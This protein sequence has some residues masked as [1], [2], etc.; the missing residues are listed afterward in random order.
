MSKSLK[1]WVSGR[2]AARAP[3]QNEWKFDNELVF[4]GDSLEPRVLLNAVV[5]VPVN[6][7]PVA[8]DDTITFNEDGSLDYR[9]GNLLAN[10][11]DPEG[12]AISGNSLSFEG[13][14]F[15]SQTNVLAGVTYDFR[16]DGNL[17]TLFFNEDGS[18]HYQFDDNVDFLAFG[19]QISE[20]FDY[21][22]VDSQGN[23]SNV[24]QL[25]VTVNGTN[26][27]P[28]F[29]SVGFSH[30]AGGLV[31]GDFLAL[32]DGIYFAPPGGTAAVVT[33]SLDIN[34]QATPAAIDIDG[35]SPIFN[36]PDLLDTIDLQIN[37]VF[38][39][40]EVP[41][42]FTAGDFKTSGTF[43]DF[44]SADGLDLSFDADASAL[45][46]LD[47]GD[48]LY[49]L[50]QITATDP[51]GE[52]A[53][54]FVKVKITG[55]E[56][57]PLLWVDDSGA[58]TEGDFGDAPITSTGVLGIDGVDEDDRS[59]FVPNGPQVGNYG[60]LSI[61]VDDNGLESWV[62]TLANESTAVQALNEG[63]VV[64]DSFY[65]AIYDN[66][67]IQYKLDSNGDPQLDAAG[68]PIPHL[69]HITI[70]I[71]GTDDEPVIT[72]E[73]AW[74][75]EGDVGHPTF[76]EGIVTIVDLDS[77]DNPTFTTNPLQPGSGTGVGT[78]GEITGVVQQ[79]NP[80]FDPADPFSPQFVE[81]YTYVP[82]QELIQFLAKDEEITDV[83]QLTA[84]D[85]TLVDDHG[86]VIVR[87]LATKS[88][89]IVIKGT[90]DAPQA[91]FD[92][93]VAWEDPDKDTIGATVTAS[94][95]VVVSDIDLSDVVTIAGVSLGPVAAQQEVLNANGD[96]VGYELIPFLR[97][98]NA[99][100]GLDRTLPGVSDTLLS[101]LTLS[102]NPVVAAG[103]D[104]GVLNWSFNSGDEGFDFLAR[105]ERA[106]INYVVT[107]VDPYGATA[108]ANI[109]VFINGKNDR[110]DIFVGEHDSASA[111]IKEGS[112]A[113]DVNSQ[114]VPGYSVT[115]TLSVSDPDASDAVTAFAGL[116]GGVTG[117]VV[118]STNPIPPGIGLTNADFL[119][120]LSLVDATTVVGV[121]ETEGLLQ[122]SFDTTEGFDFLSKGD[123]ITLTYTIEVSDKHAVDTQEVVIVIEGAN[124]R[125]TVKNQIDFHSRDYR[126][127]AANAI[128]ADD[129]DNN[130]TL[131]SDL[132]Q[133]QQEDVDVFGSLQGIA[134]QG[135]NFNFTTTGAEQ[136]EFSTDGGA[137]WTAFD[138]DLSSTNATVLSTDARVRLIPDS[139]GQNTGWAQLKFVLWD[140]TDGNASGTT[141]VNSDAVFVPGPDGE[142][143]GE[144][145][146]GRQMLYFT[147][148]VNAPAAD[149]P[150]AVD[151]TFNVDSDTVTSLP[152]IL[153]NDIDPDSPNLTASLVGAPAGVSLLPDG[154]LTFDSTGIAN[155]AI[156]FQYVV[157]DGT[158][159][160]TGTVTIVVGAP[161]FT[162]EGPENVVLSKTNT[163]YS[164]ATGGL[165]FASQTW[166]VDG[167]V[168]SNAA[169]FDLDPQG[170]GT[171][172]VTFTGTTAN[173]TVV[174]DSTTVS[175]AT[176]AVINGNLFIGGADANDS[177]TVNLVGSD[178]VVN[179]NGDVSTFAVADVTGQIVICG[180]DGD[181]DIRVGATIATNSRI[182]G[183]DGND[184]IFGGWG[185]DLIF[186]GN[187]NDVVSG[188]TGDDLILGEAGDDQLFGQVGND[189]II[190]GTG[191]DFGQ[192]GI[193]N[194]FLLGDVGVDTLEGNAGVDELFGGD[195]DDVLSGGIGND[196]VFGQDGDD[197]TNGD[198]GDD[199]VAG[200]SGDDEVIGGVGDDQLFGNL[201]DD[202][203]FGQAGEDAI[204]G[205]PGNDTIYGGN[206][207]D[208]ITAGTGDDVVFGQGGD[209]VIYG[210]AGND[211][212]TGGTGDD[213]IFGG[214]GNDLVVGN[215]GNDI[216]DGQTGND[217]LRGLGGND[218]LTGGPGV[219]VLDGGGGVDTAIDVGETE[220]LIEL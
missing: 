100:D 205:G 180:H 75:A 136:W 165:T 95:S 14:S 103:S 27:A 174:T 60:T 219:D 195:D 1:N 74:V 170:P 123:S 63:E 7:P 191:N 66:G 90:N 20:L 167:V 151:D 113:N 17:G 93:A 140:Q 4:S 43:Y 134:V 159:S 21:T 82:N 41:P 51:K 216:L 45:N 110:P 92:S 97:D 217:I 189:R 214:I 175:V 56:D 84:F 36:D 172:V 160:D 33:A 102:G 96:V 209:D 88:V 78:Y 120:M 208:A 173:G 157:T 135:V 53:T 202:I 61:V 8:N 161:Q 186:A 166:A 9:V 146:F 152:N 201:G 153:G 128:D 81:V 190:T 182:F 11:T 85:Y 206:D 16:S 117:V 52:E 169:N 35:L 119:D 37:G 177:I 98:I 73:P 131:V 138:A 212:L 104:T 6:E 155:Q 62:Y 143:H 39:D 40:G 46:Y 105:D 22:V 80:N 181:D 162:I 176:A 58:V 59:T 108:E 15:S 127:S 213:Q 185:D 72:Y 79:L 69:K 156:S 147:V 149:A 111:T 70:D 91:G 154:T 112:S 114:D 164:A 126:G 122:W 25:K 12:D 18:F 139:G 192:G 121:G 148:A 163:T 204:E 71:T 99:F 26:D 48:Q 101:Y 13:N 76:V 65:L 115:G 87:K 44:L 203:I 168:V 183:G 215:A 118:D 142:I 83:V 109:R 10:D 198:A 179:V 49:L 193:G 77:N 107:V 30:D 54:A 67:Q 145:A 68:L 55:T 94:G 137:T 197:S 220:I 29:Q 89:D 171:F 24:G 150:I 188:R 210:D 23:V 2:L 144:S 86:D 116:G 3:K 50:Y 218:T 211:D 207:N 132:I 64:Q 19:E 47:S 141:G 57:K 42:G 124:D 199:V 200:G 178:Y 5:N 31:A 32:D 106:V 28:D 38:L 125:P 184:T 34:E 130:G 129:F 194:D 133:A 196:T 158:S 187:G